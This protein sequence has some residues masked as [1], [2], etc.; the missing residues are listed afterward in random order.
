MGISEEQARGA[1]PSAVM[2]LLAFVCGLF[3]A[4]VLAVVVR[5]FPP[6][7]PLRGAQVGTFCWIGFAGAT[8]Y[9]K[10]SLRRSHGSSG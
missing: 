3:I 7:T 8:S 4:A 1:K 6:V 5:H 2:F 10:V 9:A